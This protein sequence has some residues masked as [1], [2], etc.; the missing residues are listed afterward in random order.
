MP[1]STNHTTR[2]VDYGYP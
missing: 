1:H 2:L